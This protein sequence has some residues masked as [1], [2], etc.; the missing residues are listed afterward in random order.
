[1]DDMDARRSHPI[2]PS[3]HHPIIPSLSTM[4][5]VETG[6]A[7]LRCSKMVARDG[8]WG[9]FSEMEAAK[10]FSISMIIQKVYSLGIWGY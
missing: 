5:R 7:S 9:F 10:F 1:M 3:S 4:F 8:L 6:G 2:I